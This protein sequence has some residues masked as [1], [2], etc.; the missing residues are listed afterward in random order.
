MR[1]KEPSRRRHAHISTTGSTPESFMLNKRYLVYSILTYVSAYRF[2]SDSLISS[3]RC[4][5]KSVD[6]VALS[7]AFYFSGT[8]TRA[9]THLHTHVHA[10][11][12]THTR[13]RT[14]THTHQLRHTFRLCNIAHFLFPKC[15]YSSGKYSTQEYIGIFLA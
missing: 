2:I 11:T 14:H 3:S 13:A 1:H 12:H 7:C 4:K 8:H 10:D 15:V 5:R 9:R 6:L